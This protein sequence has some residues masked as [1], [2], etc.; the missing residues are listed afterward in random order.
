MIENTIERLQTI[1]AEQ[2]DVNIAR[3]E[4][5]PDINLLEDGLGIDSIAVVELITLVEENFG[6]EFD[7]DG[8]NMDAFQSVRTLATYIQAQLK[9]TLVN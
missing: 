7:E 9:P 1:I 8:L 2:L 6:F 3:E 4:V 5:D